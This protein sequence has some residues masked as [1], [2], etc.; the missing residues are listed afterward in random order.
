MKTF[1]AILVF[2]IPLSSHAYVLEHEL[3]EYNGELFVSENDGLR[4]LTAQLGGKT[5]LHSSFKVSNPTFCVDNYARVMSLITSLSVSPDQVFNIGLGG[6][7]LPRFHF[8]KY[9]DAKV[10][11]VELDPK[12]VSLAKQYFDV[13]HEN[14]SIITGDGAVVL[15]QSSKKY[16]VIWVD[17]AN[18]YIG[19]PKVFKTEEFN[20][21]LRSHLKPDGI[22]IANLWERSSEKMNG[23]ASTYKS[24]FLHGIRVKVPLAINEII[25]V[26]NHATLTC[27]NFW[28]QYSSWYHSEDF[29]LKWV[30]QPELRESQVCQEL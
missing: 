23:L 25:A 16:D 29:P 28:D 20:Q 13:E 30:G 9:P 19:V 14:H 24:G 1:L 2:L 17:A 8:S 6:G 22:V 11:S 7:V 18:P 27:S 5:I 26:S 10:D 12:V 15:Q 21:T 3:S 4:T